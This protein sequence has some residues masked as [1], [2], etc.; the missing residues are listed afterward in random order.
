M[1]PFDRTEVL[2]RVEGDLDLF[3]AL[4]EALRESAAPFMGGGGPRDARSAHNLRGALLAVAAHP[5][6]EAALAIEKGQGRE[7][8]LEREL[9][10]LFAA[11]SRFRSSGRSDPS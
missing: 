6:A 7:E 11:I 2:S 8:R 3:D 10:D 4:V 5:A 9:V 1:Q